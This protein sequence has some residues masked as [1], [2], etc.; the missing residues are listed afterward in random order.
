METLSE[1]SIQ[2]RKPKLMQ[3]P[4]DFPR[5]LAQTLLFQP[6]NRSGI[7]PARPVPHH[8]CAGIKFEGVYIKDAGYGQTALAH[9][10][11][12]Q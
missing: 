5:A 11:G 10:L 7:Q 3:E 2:P 6:G 12:D 9:S 4:P 1:I 8:D